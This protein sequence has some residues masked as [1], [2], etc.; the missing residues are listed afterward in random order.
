MTG[1]PFDDALHIRAA[2]VVLQA[3]GIVAIPTET[4]YGLAADAL[5]ASAVAKIYEVKG[6][7]SINPLIIHVT[8]IESAKA[9]SSEWPIV[10][11]QLAEVFWPGPL[12]LVVPKNPIVPHAVTAGL[13]NVAIRIPSHPVMRAVINATGKPLAAPSAN[14]SQALS[15]TQASHVWKSLGNRVELILDAGSTEHGLEST[16]VDCTVVPPRVLRPGPVTIAALE[17]VVGRVTFLQSHITEDVAHPSPGMSQKH[18]SPQAHLTVVPAKDL[19][20]AIADANAPVGALLLSDTVE[21]N[22]RAMLVQMPTDPVAYGAVLFA[23]LHRMD[24]RGIMNIIV[25]DLPSIPEWD[26]VRDRL[27]RA[28]A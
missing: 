17:R 16:V 25:E 20:K 4:V 10:A 14:R 11:Q 21:L 2:A 27:I 3:G 23:E 26:A 8:S 12:T 28:S 9:L 22:A 18:Y 24:D 15:P 6:R 5:N 13:P 19:S 7:P 1:N